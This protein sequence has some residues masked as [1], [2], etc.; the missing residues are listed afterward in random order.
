MRLAD[1]AR[2]DRRADRDTVWKFV[3]DPDCYPQFMANLER[4]ETVTGGP[5]GGRV[6]LHRALEDRLGADRRRRRGGRVRRQPATCPGSASPGCR[7]AA[8]FGYGTARTAG[9]G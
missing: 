1:G 4:W 6:P 2:S 3:S 5:V 7:N 8:G 9:R